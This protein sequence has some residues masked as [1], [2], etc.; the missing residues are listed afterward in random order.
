MI[1]RTPLLE[2][3][4]ERRFHQRLVLPATADHGPLAITYA[5]IGP[6]VDN[7]GTPTPTIL[8]IQGMGGSRLWCYH[9]DHEANQLG[10]RMLSIDRYS[11]FT[12][13]V[14][15]IQAN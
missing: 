9:K 4:A 7:N 6:K 12:A 3:T 11:P 1:D 13:S 5:D 10:V 15:T 2:F 8:L 14:S